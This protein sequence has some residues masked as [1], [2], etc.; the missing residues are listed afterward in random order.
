MG[1]GVSQ[2][3]QD[4]GPLTLDEIADHYAAL[5]LR[6][7]GADINSTHGAARAGRKSARK[8]GASG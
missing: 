7:L 3:F 4:G 5:A 6:Q 1:I 2:W 8:I